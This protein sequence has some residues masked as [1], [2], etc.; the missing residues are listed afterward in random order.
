MFPRVECPQLVRRADDLGAE[1]G[2]G[3][4]PASQFF[5]RCRGAIAH[6]DADCCS[7]I[8]QERCAWHQDGVVIDSEIADDVLSRGSREG[9]ADPAEEPTTRE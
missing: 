6:A 8:W 9:M 4:E 7:V 3:I 5:H 2:E 1:A